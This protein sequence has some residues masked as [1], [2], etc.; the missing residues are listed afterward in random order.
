MTEESIYVIDGRIATVDDKGRLVWEDVPEEDESLD[1]SE[2]LELVVLPSGNITLLAVPRLECILQTGHSRNK[3]VKAIW[4]HKEIEPEEGLEDNEWDFI[5]EWALAKFCD[6]E[7]V[8]AIGSTCRYFRVM[9][10]TYLGIQDR[11]AAFIFDSK[12]ARA[13]AEAERL[14]VERTKK[15]QE[16]V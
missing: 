2:G 3:L 4:K 7:S 13:T 9:P 16:G 6:N 8:V 15:H 10:S 14:E 5:Y 1:D 12:V 11:Y